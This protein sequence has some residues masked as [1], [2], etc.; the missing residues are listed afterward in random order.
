VC[1]SVCVCECVCVSICL[2]IIHFI[3]V[4]HLFDKYAHISY[5][6]LISFLLECYEVA[7]STP[8]RDKDKDCDDAVAERVFAR[9]CPGDSGA[10]LI[11]YVI[12][13]TCPSSSSSASSSATNSSYLVSGASTHTRTNAH[14]HGHIHT[15]TNTH[16]Q[17]SILRTH[18]DGDASD[19]QSC[20]SIQI[21]PT[22]LPETPLKTHVK[23]PSRRQ[24]IG[25]S[26]SG[27]AFRA[28]SLRLSL[29]Q[30][31]PVSSPVLVDELGGELSGE[32][33][34]KGRESARGEVKGK[35]R[36]LGAGFADF[37][38]YS[39]STA[40]VPST[41]LSCRSTP[42]RL[43]SCEPLCRTLAPITSITTSQPAR[44][45]IPTPTP[46]PTPTRTRTTTLTLT[47]TPTRTI[48][49]TPTTA[50][51]TIHTLTSASPHKPAPAPTPIH[52]TEERDE[53]EES[54]LNLSIRAR[55]GDFDNDCDRDNVC[56]SEL[57]LG[58]DGNCDGYEGRGGDSDLARV[59][60]WSEDNGYTVDTVNSNTYGNGEGEIEWDSEKRDG[61]GNDNGNDNGYYISSDNREL[62]G[63]GEG[64]EAVS[65]DSQEDK[66]KES[67][68]YE[69]AEYFIPLP[70]LR[71]IYSGSLNSI[72]ELRQVTTL[73]LNLDSYLPEKNQD[74]ISLQ[75]FFFLL[76]QILSE[77]GGF[78]RQ[79]LVDDKVSLLCIDLNLIHRLTFH[80]LIIH[81]V[82]LSMYSFQD[83][84]L[85]RL[86]VLFISSI[87][88][89]FFPSRAV[90]RSRC[91]VCPPSHTLTTTPEASP[92]L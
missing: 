2:Y 60:D 35:G 64:L 89:F 66:E 29:R 11:D 21:L 39:S 83:Y 82:Y 72:A 84:I 8:D 4:K 87:I 31:P 90:L 26:I 33:K 69:A 24:S 53:D 61:R 81:I 5:F 23:T 79:F 47:T 3:F 74:P 10:Y 42:P 85:R 17:G 77:T 38:G 63:E 30:L 75:S 13:T 76:Q 88:S 16:I 41:V 20:D 32:T 68:L 45:H 6:T 7:V 50:L 18:T 86:I 48:T 46:T 1:V 22:H 78:L 14:T 55:D 12:N 9:K 15:R 43:L 54:S 19:I 37:M 44:T 57:D 36:G 40:T 27:H 62:E 34:K 52:G 25:R 71:A 58:R 51:T 28:M 73:F 67:A 65:K 92:L 70:A 91:G 80:C 59:W 49:N 56:D